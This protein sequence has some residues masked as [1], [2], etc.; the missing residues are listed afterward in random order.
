MVPFL[1]SAEDEAIRNQNSSNKVFAHSMVVVLKK[2]NLVFFL[3]F[4]AVI[5]HIAWDLPF[6]FAQRIHNV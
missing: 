3:S 1:T 4:G 6:G 5:E 2:N